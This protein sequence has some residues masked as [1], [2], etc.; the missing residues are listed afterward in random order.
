MSETTRFSSA[1]WYSEKRDIYVIG[2][3][4]IG[5]WLALNL[6]RIG[7]NLVLIDGDNV[8]RTNVEGGQMYRTKD[9]GKAK[10][11]A[12]HEICREFGCRNTIE[13][14]QMNYSH[15]EFGSSPITICGVDNMAARKEIFEAWVG[16]NKNSESLYIDGRLL[17][18]NMEIF[19]I[20]G[21]DEEAIKEYREKWLFNDSEVADLDCTAKQTSFGAMTIAGIMTATL[22]NWLTNKKLGADFREVNFHQ[23]LYLPLFK[24]EL[25]SIEQL[26]EA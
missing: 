20:K 23:K 5:S 11:V 16:E 24:H 8:D 18:E 9:V 17:M 4:G 15:D 10:T 6:A 25:S 1:D 3:G 12:V 13:V 19:A 21:D 22:C 26:E 2:I 14:Y 7:H